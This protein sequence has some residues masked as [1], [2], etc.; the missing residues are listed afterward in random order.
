RKEVHTRY[1][2]R[3]GARVLISRSAAAAFSAAQILWLSVF[4]PETGSQ[5]RRGKTGR[6]GA[7]NSLLCLGVPFLPD[8]HWV[9]D[10]WSGVPF[11][12]RLAR[13]PGGWSG[14]PFPR[15]GAGSGG[16][17]RGAQSPPTHPQPVSN[18]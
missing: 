18:G 6:A 3:L 13:G 10:G 8:L 14:V 1:S 12:A 17:N 9:P 11:P 5:A 16:L 4:I 15:A 2:G 7:G